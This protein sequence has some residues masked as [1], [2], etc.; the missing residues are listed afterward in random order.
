MNTLDR[1]IMLIKE[2]GITQQ[3]FLKDVGL[4]KTALSDWKK[5]VNAS[6]KK[7]INKIADYFNVS[8]DYLL[9]RENMTFTET[10]AQ[11][12]INK[13]VGEFESLSEDNQDRV[14]EYIRFLKM[15]EEEKRAK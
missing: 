15:L 6:Y 13:L 1:I 8:V 14:L 3:Q 12:K 2:R 9:G 7:H 5:G 11:K 10:E 4:N